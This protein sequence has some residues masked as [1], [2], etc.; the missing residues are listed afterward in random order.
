MRN[1]LLIQRSSLLDSDACI[2]VSERDLGIDE[3]VHPELVTCSSST[4]PVVR[5]V[6]YGTLSATDFSLQATIDSLD[7][8]SV[9]WMGELLPGSSVE[10]ELEADVDFFRRTLYDVFS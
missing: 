5:I 6:N 1:T 8:I 4:V 7:S 9:V 10:I 3:V 2:P